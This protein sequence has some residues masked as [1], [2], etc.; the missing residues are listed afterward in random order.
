MLPIRALP[1]T[2]GSHDSHNVYRSRPSSFAGRIRCHGIPV[3]SPETA[4]PITRAI[5]FAVEAGV[6]SAARLREREAYAQRHGAQLVDVLS[7]ADRVHLLLVLK[8]L[9]PHASFADACATIHT[10]A[11]R[12]T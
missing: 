12:R 9:G 2:L 8:A 11:Q 7:E 10:H 6:L 4:Q 5:R 1:A 3:I